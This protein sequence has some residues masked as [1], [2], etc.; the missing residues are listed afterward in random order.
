MNSIAMCTTSSVELANMLLGRIGMAGIPP[1]DVVVM[2]VCGDH[3]D[4]ARNPHAQVM[5]P[6]PHPVSHDGLIVLMTQ[7][8]TSWDGSVHPQTSQAS[9]SQ[10]VVTITWLIPQVVMV[11]PQIA[12]DLFNWGVSWLESI[13][14]AAAVRAG[15]ILILV[16]IDEPLVC[17]F[18]ME[19]FR[20][21]GCTHVFGPAYAHSP[22]RSRP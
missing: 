12:H 2:E 22:D 14:I 9:Q 11:N 20:Q 8:R 7:A 13:Q 5:V 4:D 3:G 18:I 19:T 15:D 1:T 6:L 16:E 10:H 17:E 21:S